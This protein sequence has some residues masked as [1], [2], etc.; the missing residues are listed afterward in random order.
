MVVIDNLV[1]SNESPTDT[2]SGWAEPFSMQ[3]KSGNDKYMYI[4]PSLECVPAITAFPGGLRKLYTFFQPVEG[5]RVGNPRK[6]RISAK[7]PTMVRKCA[8]TL[9]SCVGASGRTANR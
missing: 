6:P 2:D 9:F 3:F 5:C 8:F 4:S 1:N 7:N